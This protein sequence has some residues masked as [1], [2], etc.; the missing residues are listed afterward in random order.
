M[1]GLGY[2]GLPLVVAFAEA[3]DEVVARRRRSAQGRGASRPASRTSRTSRPSGCARC[4]RRSGPPTDYADLA[5]ADAVLICVP[6]PLTAN[7]EPDLGP[8]TP[9]A[10]AL[11]QVLQRGPAGRARVDHLPRH[12]PRAAACRCSSESGL[13]RRAGPQRRL[14]ARARRPGADRLHA[15]QHAEGDR[16]DDPSV[17]RAR[18]RALRPRVRSHRAGLDARGRGDDQAAGEHL[19]LGQH[20]AGQRARDPRRP[21][22]HRHLG[23]GRRRRHQAVRVHALR[24]RARGWA[25]TA[26]RSTRST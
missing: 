18:R 8:L 12:D 5:Q 23:G 3:G 15:A 20:R 14:L 17:R 22:G 10:T 13:T 26:C 7:R 24:A 19:P 9:P 25:A 6:T 2:V 4:S 1:I 16:R 21:D 11:A